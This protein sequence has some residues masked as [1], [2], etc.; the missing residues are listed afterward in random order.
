[1]DWPYSD[2]TGSKI[3]PAVVVLADYLK[4]FRRLG[5]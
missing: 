2:R 1:V 4:R 3:R 5:P